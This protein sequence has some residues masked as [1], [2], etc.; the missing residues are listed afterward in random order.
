MTLRQARRLIREIRAP[1]N[2]L[3]RPQFYGYDWESDDLDRARMKLLDCL[4]WIELSDTNYD[5][6]MLQALRHLLNSYTGRRAVRVLQAPNN[7]SH[8]QEEYRNE[9]TCRVRNIRRLIRDIPP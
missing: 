2:I 9:L 3:N 1:N 5:I 4:V 6:R 7:V 8:Y